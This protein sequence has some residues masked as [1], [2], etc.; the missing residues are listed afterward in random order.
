MKLDSSSSYT[1][2]E[3]CVVGLGC[4]LPGGENVEQWWDFLLAAKPAFAEMPADR[5][6]PEIYVSPS[7]SRD[8]NL[9]TTYSSKSAWISE[10][11]IQKIADISGV[12][13][14]ASTRFE[15]LL[16]E[17]TRQALVG[18]SREFVG[19]ARTG[20]IFGSMNQDESISKWDFLLEWEKLTAAASAFPD[21]GNLREDGLE[22]LKAVRD[23]LLC[24]APPVEKTTISTSALRLLRERF[25]LTGEGW[26][27]DA[28]CASSLAA[29]HASIIKLNSGELDL[30]LT[31]GIEANLSPE[32]F[33]LFARLGVLADKNC[34]PLFTNST[35]MRQGEGCAVFALT[36]LSLARKHGLKVHGI[37][38]GCAGTTSVRSNALFAPD[39]IAQIQA[40][41]NARLN[42]PGEKVSY[43]ECHATGTPVG[44][45]VEL[46]ALKKGYADCDTQIPVSS[47]KSL[48]GHTKSTA[49]AAGLLKCLLILR[50]RVIPSGIP[51]DGSTD[52]K[53]LLDGFNDGK[54]FV[55]TNAIE[56]PKPELDKPT[57]VALNSAGFGGINFHCLI[58]SYMGHDAPIAQFD[59]YQSKSYKIT[60]NDMVLVAREV[61]HSDGLPEKMSSSGLRLP[62]SSFA[63]IDDS[64]LQALL[65]AK[66]ILDTTQFASLVDLSRVSVISASSDSLPAAHNMTRRVRYNEFRKRPAEISEAAARLFELRET[67]PPITEDT[68]PGV[69]NN[70]LASRVAQTF[71][72]SGPSYNIDSDLLCFPFAVGAA[73]SLLL[74]N[75]VDAVLLVSLERYIGANPFGYVS[76]P[77]IYVHLLMN[78]QFALDLQLP[79]MA[80]ISSPEFSCALTPL[81]KVNRRSAPPA[82]LFDQPRGPKSDSYQQQVW[83][84]CHGDRI[85]LEYRP[86]IFN[87]IG[88]TKKSHGSFSK[89]AAILFSG[90]GSNYPGMFRELWSRIG[91]FNDYLMT[92]DKLCAT[93]S[94]AMVSKYILSPDELSPVDVNLLQNLALFTSQVALFEE[95]KNKVD[96]RILTAHSFGE[97]AML[98]AA[99]VVSFESMF[100]FLIARE[101]LAPPANEIGWLLAVGAGRNESE[102]VLKDFSDSGQCSLAIVNS[103]SQSVIACDN[104]ALAIITRQ[105]EALGF[106]CKVLPT[107]QPYHSELLRDYE[108]KLAVFA[109]HLDMT[110]KVPTVPFMSSVLGRVIDSSS[111]LR[112]VIP[113]ILRSQLTSPVNFVNQI[114]AVEERSGA[115]VFFEIGPRTV[116]LPFVAQ[117]L[118]KPATLHAWG[119]LYDRSVRKEV[120]LTDLNEEV[121]S[122]ITSKIVGVVSRVVSKV[123][124]YKLEGISIEDRMQDDLGIDSIKKAEIIFTTLGQLQKEVSPK[125][126]LSKILKIKDLVEYVHGLEVGQSDNEALRYSDLF[127]TYRRLWKKSDIRNK[128]SL[129]GP[130]RLAP[131]FVLDFRSQEI[132]DLVSQDGFSSKIFINKITESKAKSIAVVL[133]VVSQSVDE[134]FSG[135]SRALSSLVEVAALVEE[136]GV[137]RFTLVLCGT[138]SPLSS[139]LVAMVKSWCKEIS[140]VA[141][142]AI[143]LEGVE[144]DVDLTAL[145]QLESTD[146]VNYDVKY[147][148]RQRYITGI[149]VLN[150]NSNSVS[151]QKPASSGNGEASDGAIIVF[152]GAK[153]ITFSLLASLDS[154]FHSSPVVLVGRT[155]PEQGEILEAVSTLRA[156]GFSSVEYRQSDASILSEVNSVFESAVAKYHKVGMV[157]NGAGIEVS[158]PFNKKTNGDIDLELNGKILPVV[159]TQFCALKCGAAQI[160]H[161]SSIVSFYGNAGQTVYAA[162]NAF[163]DSFASMQNESS[164]IRTTSI[165]WPPWD[166]V[167][168]TAVPMIKHSL[169][170]SGLALLRGDAASRIF[171]KILAAHTRGSVLVATDSDRHLYQIGLRDLR[172]VF[173]R[174]DLIESSRRSLTF[175]SMWSP[176]EWRALD[177]H[178]VQGLRYL[179]AAAMILMFERAVTAIAGEGAGT[180]SDFEVLQ[181]LII[182]TAQIP[183]RLE[184]S[185]RAVAE[186]DNG[187]KPDICFDLVLWAETPIAR[188]SFAAKNENNSVVFEDFSVRLENS[189]NS[190]ERNG[191]IYGDD[192]LFHGRM[193]QVLS[194]VFK[195]GER[196]IAIPDLLSNS[197]DAYSSSSRFESVEF[198]TVRMIDAV[199]QLSAL[200]ASDRVGQRALP[201]S[202]DSIDLRKSLSIDQNLKYKIVSV[203][204]RQLNEDDDCCFF[205][206][207]LLGPAGDILA[208]FSGIKIQFTGERLVQHIKGKASAQN[209]EW[210]PIDGI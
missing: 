38:R 52:P 119:D 1:G 90:Q 187:K 123:T 86:N 100:R 81:T 114:H 26:F 133:A 198:N 85:R 95:K 66:R 10:K 110:Y 51:D 154:T 101:T 136:I 69:L 159:N 106:R 88:S 55:S 210:V 188:V 173:P 21:S 44:D 46:D 192:G 87:V 42:A 208:V 16:H 168:M 111:D 39:A 104:R 53:S 30:V 115:E 117:I 113:K 209:I 79:V 78:K 18:F 157:I 19:S 174:W 2:D 76:A 155:S 45:R 129:E 145:V 121:A 15:I 27:V 28:A 56:L 177:D 97:F 6:N 186:D 74:S 70:V 14:K 125:L 47:V 89:P 137:K 172:G 60:S 75:Q 138:E 3:V 156:K 180:Y 11:I 139:A 148:D 94:L 25:G 205:D 65:A 22:L 82:L 36:R 140:G 107:P 160:I 132:R 124:G 143:M 109:G 63:S 204:H 178:A 4:V 197:M 146:E 112:V 195:S 34:S 61:E 165:E 189:R 206:S 102:R 118:K 135:L 130:L 141:F 207:A 151:S 35:G 84:S 91:V 190:M 73:K 147:V 185:P 13:R 31:G 23:E 24:N 98:V 142:K 80:N 194:K 144:A 149:E 200:S 120:V 57:M 179:P 167:G 182:G 103:P 72:F 127:Q 199:M 164:N 196:Y 92:A 50:H 59:N 202:V 99:G 29:I 48:I 93:E 9:D 203:P 201:V 54:L 122:G 150:V 5:L 83:E 33:A 64:Q 62:P 7:D 40:I 170:S 58:Q 131:Q 161:F 49:G 71:G 163:I 181:P 12:D 41:K 171:N 153:G 183:I 162:A 126:N 67:L 37:I 184:I 191:S 116:L 158:R 8:W 166:A 169:E 128:N 77:E 20:M 96:F 105:F 43:I 68:G 17:A 108:T 32:S 152:G 193:F 176:S 134:D 175:T